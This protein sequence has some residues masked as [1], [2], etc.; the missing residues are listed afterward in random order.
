MAYADLSRCNCTDTCGAVSLPSA[1][2]RHGQ[3]LQAY[4]ISDRTVELLSTNGLYWANIIDAIFLCFILGHGILGFLEVQ[5]TQVS[6][7]GPHARGVV[8]A[9]HHDPISP[10]KMTEAESRC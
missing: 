4:L 10:N 8:L 3:N 1:P 9:D 6:I 5:F 2:F 7:N